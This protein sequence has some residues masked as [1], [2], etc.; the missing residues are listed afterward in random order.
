MSKMRK[1]LGCKG[2]FKPETDEQ[3]FC[4][5]DCRGWCRISIESMVSKLKSDENIFSVFDHVQLLWK[6]EA[7]GGEES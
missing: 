4:S 6:K 3:L 5:E 7:Q 2:E 1:C